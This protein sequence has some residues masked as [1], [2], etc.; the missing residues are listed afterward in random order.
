MLRTDQA[1]FGLTVLWG[2][3]RSV[4]A[5]PTSFKYS[6]FSPAN[7]I[8]K[9]DPGRTAVPPVIDGLDHLDQPKSLANRLDWKGILYPHQVIV[10]VGFWACTQIL[11]A[12]KAAWPPGA[13]SSQIARMRPKECIR[14]V[15]RVT[16]LQQPLQPE[17][18]V[19]NGPSQTN[20]TQ[21]MHGW[22]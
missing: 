9:P 18:R 3:F 13:A 22:E 2:F 19:S 7:A 12:G 8:S 4:Q 14:R 20:W 11:K 17:R 21:H 15:S 6:E 5:N 16:L 10:F 1:R